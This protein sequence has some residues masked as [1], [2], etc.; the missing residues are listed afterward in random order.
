MFEFLVKAR[1]I[2]DALRSR[3]P[4]WR[5]FGGFSVHNQVRMGAHDAEGRKNLAGYMLRAPMSLENIRY[6][7]ATGSVIYRSKM[8]LGLKRNF[9]VMVGAEWLELLL[10]HVPDRYEHLVRYVGWYSNRA[11]GERAKALRNQDTPRTSTAPVEPVSEFAVRAKAA[12]ARLIGKIYEADPLECPKCEGPMRIIALIDDPG[13][14][15]RILEHLGLWGA[16]GKRVIPAARARGMAGRR[17]HS[18]SPHISPRP[19]HRVASREAGGSPTAGLAPSRCRRAVPETR[20]RRRRALHIGRSRRRNAL[21]INRRT[22]RIQ[23]TRPHPAQHGEPARFIFL[24]LGMDRLI[25]K[26]IAFNKRYYSFYF[27]F[28]P[29]QYGAIPSRTGKGNRQCRSNCRISP[30]PMAHLRR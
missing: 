17:G 26:I 4:G 3:L 14:I 7:I 28:E 25:M 11:R 22:P 23:A 29:P 15:R 13:V 27:V 24:S 21:S 8:H 12:W 2:T 9:Q 10:R 6:D 16:R 5:H 1:A 18:P 19:R 20:C 30:T